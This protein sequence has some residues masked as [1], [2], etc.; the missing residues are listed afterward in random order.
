MGWGTVKEVA[1]YLVLAWV[2][3]GVLYAIIRKERQER[4][5]RKRGWKMVRRDMTGRTFWRR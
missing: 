5:L 4:S 1:S 2:G 3:L